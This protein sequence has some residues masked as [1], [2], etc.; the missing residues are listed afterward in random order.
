MGYF[1]NATEAEMY[2]VHYCARCVHNTADDCPVLLAH[3][4]WNYDE[5]NNPESILHKMIP[6]ESTSNGQCFAFVEKES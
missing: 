1:S 6:R 3:S 2:Q 4:L 5:C